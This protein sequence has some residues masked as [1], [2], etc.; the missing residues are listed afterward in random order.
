MNDYFG[1]VA[2]VICS[3]P[4]DRLVAILVDGKKVWPDSGTGLDRSGQ[5]NPV[6]LTVTGYGEAWLY[7]G[8][9]TQTLDASGEA[10][11]AT[12][13]HP[14][15]RRQ[16]V[17]SLKKFLFGREKVS[18]PSVA[19]IVRRTPVQSIVT[20]TAALLDADGQANPLA[21][22]AELL[23][24]PVFGLGLPDT[25]FDLDSW[26][27]TADALLAR[28]STTYISPVFD[29]PAS[30]RSLV[31][32]LR[33]YFDGWFRADTAAK[34][35]A[36]RFLHGEAAPTF[37]SSN[38]LTA[39]DLLEEPSITSK[40]WAET[41]N[42]LAVK[43]QDAENAYKDSAFTITSGY[44][45]QIT[46]EPRQSNFERPHITRRAQ[47]AALASEYLKLAAEPGFSATLVVRAPKGVA[48]PTGTI[49]KFTH[50][51]L[52]VDLICRVTER[53]E[54]APPSERVTLRIEAERGITATPVPV[55]AGVSIITS[56]NGVERLPRF[57][58]AMPPANLFGESYLLV[59]LV[60]RRV[61]ATLGFNLFYRSDDATQLQELG[62]Q[63]TFA[64]R[65]TLTQAYAANLGTPD[66]NSETLRIAIDAETT[67]G[68]LERV[69]TALTEDEVQDD[70]LLLWIIRADNPNTV[71]ILSVR[72]LRL[73]SGQWYAKVRRAQGGTVAASFAAAD[74]CWLIRYE[75]LIT[76]RHSRLPALAAA[77][78][79]VTLRLQ[80]IGFAGVEAALDDATLCPD[81]AW[82]LR[83]GAPA[84]VT[85]FTVEGG[86][87][88][89]AAV[90][91]KS[92][93]GYRLR[94]QPGTRQE[95]SDATD[96]HTGII[97]TNPFEPTIIPKGSTTF[98]VKAVDVTGA[99]S[100]NA[101]VIVTNLG[102]PLVANVVETFD[103][104]SALWPGTRSGFAIDG[105]NN[106]AANSITTMWAADETAPMWA[107]DGAAVMWPAL[108]YA[109]ATYIDSVTIT[110]ALAGST[111]T[112]TST[113]AGDPWKIEYRENSPASMWAVDANAAM[114]TDDASAFWDVPDWQA[115]PGQ[116]TVSGN[117][118]YDFR[119]S[120]G[121]AQ[122]QGTVTAFAVVV[123][124]PD[125]IE[126]INNAVLAS[127]GTR[128]ALTKTY[129]VIKNISL[130]I[131]QDGNGAASIQIL[132]KLKAGPLVRAF[133]TS[134][135]GVAAL[136]D[137]TIQGY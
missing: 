130:T 28:A 58:F 110:Q 118:I 31:D 15:Y 85:T 39:D 4:I 112:L 125:V 105:S 53:T 80:A 13:G 63:G 121:E 94:Y 83:P 23:T 132:D 34:I 21:V 97:T 59:P 93:V 81:L 114:W 6:Q 107:G 20:G 111:M 52:G 10:N 35:V 56:G 123:D 46:G 50:D 77:G 17:L 51:L 7:W 116:V 108:T 88:S 122:T 127:G 89:W 124:A 42:E 64:V 66:D 79:T 60:A 134:G 43:F 49:L 29:R 135:T 8:T 102:D 126:S 62:T 101:A 84:D 117:T 11:L 12:G 55:V 75:D 133:N 86:R 47:I 14:A 9:A 68:D 96:L 98:L 37:N 19:C 106:L 57:Y 104:R 109:A 30:A 73:V 33:G 67:A 24:H 113:V 119:I 61:A 87:F 76:Y 90:D 137:A 54:A 38:T 72:A 36:G 2:G 95:W 41:L 91:D 136:I 103:R 120:T 82:K 25:D 18:C 115:S 27:A 3:G 1:D 44:N 5:P 99:E 100:L 40:G 129:K 65:G 32:D 74:E 131:Q 16:A 92:V 22:L 45:R 71:E 69:T 128:L 48:Y 26:Q 70:T 78:A